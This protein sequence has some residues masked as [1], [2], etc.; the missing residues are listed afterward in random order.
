MSRWLPHACR[1]DVDSSISSLINRQS[2]C[3]AAGTLGSFYSLCLHD[4]VFLG[5][6][7]GGW[8]GGLRKE[9]EPIFFGH[10]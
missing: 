6:G 9:A 4:V 10:G 2:Y 1:R 5:G 8:L 3:V 7:L